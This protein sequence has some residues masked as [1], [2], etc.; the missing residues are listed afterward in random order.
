[1]QGDGIYAEVLMEACISGVGVCLATLS[2]P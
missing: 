2:C 1:M